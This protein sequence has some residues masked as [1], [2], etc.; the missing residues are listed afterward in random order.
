MADTELRVPFTQGFP[1]RKSALIY[2]KAFHCL[3]LQI[4]KK[5][6]WLLLPLIDITGKL[7]TKDWIKSLLPDSFN[8]LF[9]IGETKDD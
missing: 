1:N 8:T 7:R 5:Y 4:L 3:M 6:D 9:P 2:M